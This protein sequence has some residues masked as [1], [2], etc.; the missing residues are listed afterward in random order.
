[1][2][3]AVT[4]CTIIY[5]DTLSSITNATVPG[6]A[7]KTKYLALSYNFCRDHFSAGIVDIRKIQ[8][9]GNYADSTT[10]ALVSS[11]SHGFMNEIMEN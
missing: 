9:K 10:K 5:E 8:T 3:V 7:L 4:K 1:M 6:S 11:E 2:G